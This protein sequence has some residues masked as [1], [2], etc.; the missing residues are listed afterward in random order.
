MKL[1]VKITIDGREFEAKEKAKVLDVARAHNIQIQTLCAH[2]SVSPYGNCR[3][4]LV[5]ITTKDGK[6]R[7]VPSCISAV[8]DGMVVKTNSEKVIAERKVSIQKLMARAPQSE[9]IKDI[10]K[11]YGVESTPFPPED[12]QNCVLCSLCTRVCAEVVGANA[13]SKINR[14]TE[15]GALPYT[16]NFE[17]CI[18]CGSCVF[19]CPT[20]AISLTDDGDTRT[21]AWP[22]QKKEFK[23]AKCKQCGRYWAPLQQV[24]NISKTSGQ[25]MAYFD[26]CMECRG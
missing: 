11:K 3:L 1:M 19:I 8:D 9:A 12:H 23:M 14:T 25:P 17:A 26:K 7:L 21:I 4:C 10:A 2:E 18:A 16:V 22:Y 24:E 15:P 6:N 13:I 20:H 5:E